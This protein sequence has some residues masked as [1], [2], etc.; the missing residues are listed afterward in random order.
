MDEAER[1]ERIVYLSDG[2]IVAQGAPDQVARTKAHAEDRVDTYR[3]AREAYINDFRVN[4]RHELAPL[5]PLEHDLRLMTA[6]TTGEVQARALFELGSVEWLSNEF[7][8]SVST[9]TRAAELATRLGRQDIA[10]DA[11][12]S[13]ARAHI[14]G[15]H[16]HGAAEAAMDSAIAAAGSNPSPKQRYEIARYDSE[17]SVARGELGGTCRGA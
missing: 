4:G 8:E 9:L 12:V 13:A 15:T 2:R 3:A 6:T 1:C 7:P 11:W 10:F 14:I 16:D 17:G 5:A